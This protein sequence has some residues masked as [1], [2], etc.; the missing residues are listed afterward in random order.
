[1]DRRLHERIVVQFEAKVTTVNNLESA[2]ATVSDISQSGISVG[3]PMQLA[4][5]DK[6]RVEMADCL[7][8]GHV[9]YSNSEGSSFRTGIDVD[10]VQLGASELSQLLQRTLSEVMPGTP[11]LEYQEAYLD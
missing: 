3:L 5:G 1:M 8:S 6:V 9:V 11:G 2:C 4:P 7:L 10:Q